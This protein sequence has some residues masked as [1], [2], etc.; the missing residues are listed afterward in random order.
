MNKS[1]FLLSLLLGVLLQV[2]AAVTTTTTNAYDFAV[3]GIYYKITST[4]EVAVSYEY[5]HVYRYRDDDDHWSVTQTHS[6]YTGAVKIP[7]TVENAGKTYRVTGISEYAFTNSKYDSDEEEWTFTGCSITSIELPVSIMSIG[8]DAFRDCSQLESVV[9]KYPYSY[10]IDMQMRKAGLGQYPADEIVDGV[11]YASGYAIRTSGN[12]PQT[13]RI[14][15]GT[16][17]IASYAFAYTNIE[18]I[19]LPSSLVYI[20]KNA[21]YS[22]GVEYNSSYLSV[23]DFQDFSLPLK[24]IIIDAP[25]NSIVGTM[26]D[27]EAFAVNYTFMHQ[28]AEALSPDYIGSITTLTATLVVPQGTKSY[29]ESATGWSKLK[30][31]VE[32][33]QPATAEIGDINYYLTEGKATIVA[34][35]SKYTGNVVIPSNVEYDAMTYT[36]TAIADS[37]FFGCSGLTAISIPASI[38]T[39]GAYAFYGCSGVQKV[40]YQDLA[41]WCNITFTNKYSN[42][43]YYAKHLYNNEG[44]ELVNLVVPDGVKNVGSYTFVK[45]ELQSVSIPSNVAM[46]GTGAFYKN[47]SLASVYLADGVGYVRANAFYGCTALTSVRL[48]DSV[49]R[50]GSSAF[51]GCTALESIVLPIGLTGSGSLGGVGNYAFKLCSNLKE[52]ISNV[53]TPSTL[54]TESFFGVD[55]VCVLEIPVGTITAYNNAGWTTE[56]FGGGIVEVGEVAENFCIENAVTTNFIQNVTYPNDDYSFTKITDYLSEGTTYRKDL[57]NPVKIEG[58]GMKGGKSLLLEIYAD[59]TLVS[60]DTFNIAAKALEVWNL[61][62][63][64]HYTYQMYVLGTDGSRTKVGRGNFDTEGQVRWMNV[65]NMGNFRDLGG[66]PT[67]K[68][69][70]IKYDKIFRSNELSYD[71]I[72]NK[73]DVVTQAGVDALL[74]EIGIGVEIDFGDYSNRSPLE[75]QIEFVHGADYQITPYSGGVKSKKPQYKN[76]FEKVV[77]SLRAGKKVLFHCNWG[78]D[79]TGTFAFLLEG[80]L[81]VSES[82]LAK[83]YELT[84]FKYNERRYRSADGVGYKG[85]IDYVKA[86]FPANSINESIELM[87]LDFGI[88]QQDIEDFRSLMTETGSNTA[89]SQDNVIGDVDGDGEISIIDVTKV[90]EMYLQ[91]DSIGE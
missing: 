84:N 88:T 14:K 62:P 51:Y 5:K 91:A 61:I 50:L 52:V 7:A 40:T 27:A 67:A 24:K 48:P 59:N 71:T 79:R 21:F 30:T 87:A 31:I 76:C 16:I 6:N 8:T 66:W 85:L 41:A 89:P 63:Q 64:T 17:G 42:P 12:L 2:Q 10:S 72:N 43:V 82:D 26:T 15:E 78:A 37:A 18:T 22:E 49:Y 54:G 4:N 46:V 86:T 25:A 56:V 81:G 47:L 33:G 3:D 65:G 28:Y 60:S 39:V 69:K 19:I 68:G 35:N 38:T 13:V 20:E 73:P 34:K 11:A 23:E 36:V 90:I 70:R 83:D 29:Y 9:C 53:Q 80:L 44:T 1:F 57:P 45:C 55:S 77:E 75:G 58:M 32:N 74:N